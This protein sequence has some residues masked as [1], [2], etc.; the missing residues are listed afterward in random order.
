M[1]RKNAQI[2]APPIQ[3]ASGLL[4]YTFDYAKFDSAML[5]LSGNA[6]LRFAFDVEPQRGDLVAFVASESKRTVYLARY[7]PRPVLAT[8][9]GKKVKSFRKQPRLFGVVKE[10]VERL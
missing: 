4:Q 9:N 3:T 10:I 5:G 6:T 1:P 7:A 2:S 8:V